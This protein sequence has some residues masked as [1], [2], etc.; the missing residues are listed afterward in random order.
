VLAEQPNSNSASLEAATVPDRAP[1]PDALPGTAGY[2]SGH[3]SMQEPASQPAPSAGRRPKLLN[4]ID[5]QLC[6]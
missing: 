5:V 4:V 1:M 3:E 6:R 2:C